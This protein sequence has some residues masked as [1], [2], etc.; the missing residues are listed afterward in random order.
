MG[1]KKKRFIYSF[2]V[3]IYETHQKR[4]P[5]PSTERGGE[6][7]DMEEEGQGAL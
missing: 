1:F 5:D 7:E 6:T 4:A 3:H 2:D